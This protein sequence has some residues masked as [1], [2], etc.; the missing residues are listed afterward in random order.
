MYEKT[1]PRQEATPLIGEQATNYLFAA[2]KP[3]SG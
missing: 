3:P 2:D 1:N